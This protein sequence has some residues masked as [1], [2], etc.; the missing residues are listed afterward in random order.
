[1]RYCKRLTGDRSSQWPQCQFLQV[2]DAVEM[3]AVMVQERKVLSTARGSWRSREEAEAFQEAHWQN[4]QRDF[5]DFKSK[6]MRL[7]CTELMIGMC[8]V[9]GGGWGCRD[10]VQDVNYPK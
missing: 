7:Q 9:Y 2:P 10:G 3:S 5:V 6:S 1:M 4:Y 8:E